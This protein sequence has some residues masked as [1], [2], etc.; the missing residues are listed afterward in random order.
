MTARPW[1]LH[2]EAIVELREAAEWYEQ[3]AI[4]LGE[5]FVAV[6]ERRLE[7]TLAQASPGTIIPYVRRPD[8][9]WLPMTPRFPYGIVLSLEP[10]TVIA[11]AHLRRRP[12]YWR[13]RSA[14]R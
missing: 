10:R 7:A 11:L 9:R 4:R 2:P 13:T 3:H 1:L 8:I 14:K 12:E 6:F 5:D